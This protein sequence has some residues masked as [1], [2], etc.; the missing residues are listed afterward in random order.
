MYV[1]D[2]E[3]RPGERQDQGNKLRKA[4]M[5]RRAPAA[6]QSQQPQQPQ[7][8]QRG[9]GGVRNPELKPGSYYKLTAEPA[10]KW[11]RRISN[12]IQLRIVICAV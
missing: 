10:D 9:I 8:P 1:I 6:Q 11:E 2:K 7:Q 5:E 12:H 4:E 3:D